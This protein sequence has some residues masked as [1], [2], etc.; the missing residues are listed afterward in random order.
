MNTQLKKILIVDDE[1]K[2][3]ELLKLMLK[4]EDYE[5]ATAN[6]G[7]AALVSV[8]QTP[9]DLILL[10]VMM[11]E[12]NG[13]KVV[14][15]L[16][17]NPSTKSIPVIMVTSLDSRDSRMTAFN[18]G[19]EEF[20]TKPVDRGELLLRVRNMLR[21]K[22]YSDLLSNYNETLISEVEERTAE[23]ESAYQ[24]TILTMV[25]AAEYKDEETG[26]HV[27]RIS[28]YT[29][30][31]ATLLGLD[32][33]MVRALKVASPMHDVG[34]IGIPDHILFK[35]TP[36]T[37]EEWTIMQTHSALG[38]KIL[39][40]ST[41]PY[42]I[43][44]AEIALNHHERWDGTGYPNGISGEAI[45]LSARIMSLCD[46]YDA[47]RSKRPYKPAFSHEKTVKIILEGDG[48]TKPEHFD[49]TILAAFATHPEYFEQ[50]YEQYK[51]GE[52]LA[53]EKLY[54]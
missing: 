49:P 36:F 31:L 30:M 51:D 9:P 18:L 41:S 13:N 10:D 7:E 20:V 39:E 35:T 2:N 37:P 45:P 21:L 28:Y 4:A 48:R 53:T 32:K 14:G 16:K 3:C 34:K 33:K 6:S 25:R 15:I 12:M 44:G 52:I 40:N 29:A 17:H 46:V 1:A 50:I 19:A 22:D 42:T 8:E 23:L 24:E 38:A 43:M 11:P 27:Q 5:L 47:L 26:A 54:E